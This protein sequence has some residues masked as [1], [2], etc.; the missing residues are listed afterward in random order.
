M[1]L[2]VAKPDLTMDDGSF[3]N[4]SPQTV[5]ALLLFGLRWITQQLLCKISTL[6][7][8]ASLSISVINLTVGPEIHSVSIAVRS[9][10][11]L[12]KETSPNQIIR[13]CVGSGATSGS[14]D[15]YNEDHEHEAQG[16]CES[17]QR[18]D[19]AYGSHRRFNFI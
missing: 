18:N 19:L 16:E 14:K 9:R 17:S 8:F 6:A 10:E 5:L 2:S 4:R 3:V 12:E 13:L 1:N 15:E 7:I 11:K